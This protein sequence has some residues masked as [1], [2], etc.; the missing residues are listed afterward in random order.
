MR[1]RH[2]QR[3]GAQR[4]AFGAAGLLLAEV[5][6]IMMLVFQGSQAPTATAVDDDKTETVAV[7][8]TDPTDVVDPTVTGIP[9]AG[10]AE[11]ATAEETEPCRPPGL[12]LRPTELPG[13][14]VRGRGDTRAAR[15]LVRRIGAGPERRPGL[16][17]LFGV[18]YDSAYPNGGVEVSEDVKR[19]LERS[20]FGRRY[21]PVIRPF[22]RVHSSAYRT[23]EVLADVYFLGNGKS[24]GGAG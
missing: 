13:V 6:L 11:P 1:T 22:L 10:A 18:S 14:V 3:A 24:C 20:A 23:G 8:S 17:L 19:M 7:G 15:E 21:R 2:S 12:R 4:T 5:A 9:V 16:I